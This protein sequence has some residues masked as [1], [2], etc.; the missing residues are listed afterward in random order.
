MSGT[1]SRRPSE[2]KFKQQK[3]SAWTPIMGPKWIIPGY[4]LVGILFIIIGIVVLTTSVSV[5]SMEVRYDLTCE[6]K[7]FNWNSTGTL[8]PCTLEFTIPDEVGWDTKEVYVYYQL[9]NFYQNHRRYSQSLS[10]S[11]MLGKGMELDTSELLTDS[12]GDSITSECRG[13]ND[14]YKDKSDDN[15]D[16]Y[17][18]P[19]GLVA[20]SMFNDTLMIRLAKTDGPFVMWGTGECPGTTPCPTNPTNVAWTSDVST[21]YNS[22]NV[23][24]IKTNCKYIGG[25][26]AARSGF[27]DPDLSTIATAAATGDCGAP[28]CGRRVLKPDGVTPNDGVF[29]C[30]HNTTDEDLMVWMRIAA[31]STFRKL[32]RKIPAGQLTRGATYNLVVENRFPVAGFKG[33]KSLVLSTSSFLGGKNSALSSAYFVVGA[34]CVCASIF[35]LV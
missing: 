23:D 29:N 21:R 18:Y 27:I 10:G 5:L 28:A 31:L 34:I 14:K 1:P 16:V 22:P 17:M 25:Q 32:Y 19:C 8:T 2:S 30:W 6:E 26:D 7:I 4:A 3:L 11:Q 15:K 33:S 24:W 35:F 9:E 12:D 20:S 13:F